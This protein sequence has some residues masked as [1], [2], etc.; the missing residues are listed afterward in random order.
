MHSVGDVDHE[1][2]AQQLIAVVVHSRGDPSAGFRQLSDS[3]DI[4]ICGMVEDHL[5]AV[6]ADLVTTSR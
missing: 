4:R 3:S 1:T 5:R 2:L 6:V